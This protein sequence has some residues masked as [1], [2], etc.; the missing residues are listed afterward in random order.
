MKVSLVESLIEPKDI[1]IFGARGDEMDARRLRKILAG[2]VNDLVCYFVRI[3][4]L[5]KYIPCSLY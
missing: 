5:A 1:K 3:P 4:W 2:Q